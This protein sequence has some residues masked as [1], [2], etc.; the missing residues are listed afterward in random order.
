MSKGDAD[1]VQHCVTSMK[2][3]RDDEKS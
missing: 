3:D 2:L 1:W